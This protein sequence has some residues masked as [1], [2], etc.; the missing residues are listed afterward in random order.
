MNLD[1]NLDKFT[2][3]K[4]V[5]L[6]I[7]FFA[8]ILI[9]LL[10][11][12]IPDILY[13]IISSK[14]FLV[15]GSLLIIFKNKEVSKDFDITLLC[16]ILYFSIVND[17]KY[18]VKEVKQLM[19]SQESNETL[20]VEEDT[21]DEDDEDDNQEDDNKEDDNKEDEA[22]NIEEDKNDNKNI[23]MK[24][25][26]GLLHNEEQNVVSNLKEEDLNIFEEAEFTKVENMDN[27]HIINGGNVSKKQLKNIQGN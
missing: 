12:V 25:N 9:Q 19:D 13:T 11:I 23:E 2:D 15:I 14:V 18:K 5:I 17:K 10:D 22:M 6:L 7:L 27:S 8:I 20:D 3:P 24:Q 21:D 1:M 16:I 4:T 26:W